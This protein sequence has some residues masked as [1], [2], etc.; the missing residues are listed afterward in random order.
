MKNKKSQKAVKGVT[1]AFAELAAQVA[2]KKV[3]PAKS[4]LTSGKCSAEEL[5]AHNEKL[6][7]KLAS[8]KLVVQHSAKIRFYA[9]EIIKK[10][11]ETGQVY[12]DLCNYIRDNLV[13][14][15]L[16]SFELG[17]M[18]FN[19]QVVSRINKVANAADDVYSQFAARLIGFNKTLELARGP[20]VESLA[21]EMGTTV[22]DVKAQVEELES[23][24]EKA[25]G[26]SSGSS[27]SQ[28]EEAGPIDWSDQ[29]EKTAARLMNICALMGMKRPKT[30]TGNNGYLITIRR[31]PKWKAPVTGADVEG[32]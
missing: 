19:R 2:I 16:V 5:K 24:Q 11:C 26:S 7:A 21:E 1:P 18:G 17:E 20:V 12:L 3:T 8:D 25:G 6:D 14:P 15:K 30:V 31:N 28:G 10:T 23:N 4:A 9:A 13:A 32:K 29:F 22:I 27:S